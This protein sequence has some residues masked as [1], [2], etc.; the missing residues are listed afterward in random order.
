MKRFLPLL[1]A[2]GVALFAV[3]CGGS[4][5]QAVPADAV[6]VVGDQPIDKA[7]FD[8]LMEQA[9]TSYEAQERDFPEA[10]TPEYN[11][12]RNQA[13]Q[14]LVQRAQFEQK[15]AEMDVEVTDEEVEERLKQIKEQYFGGDEKKYEEQL[16]QQGLSDEQVRRDIRA[17]LIQEKLFEKVTAD[18]E[19]TDEEI[20]EHYEQNKEQYGQP[21]S[22]EVRHILVENQQQANRIRQQLVNGGNFEALAKQHSKDP[23]SA[24]QGGKMTVSRGQTVPEFDKAAFSL[25]KDAISQPVKTQY[26]FHIIQP[27]SAVQPAKTTPLN[28]VRESIRQQLLQTKRNERMT[29]WVEETKQEFA[30]KTRYQ[31]GYAPPATTAADE[32]QTET[33]DR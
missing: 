4:E 11:T 23:G 2:L 10:G 14:F 15:A 12:L 16:E 21:E 13:M 31:V 22:R 8:Q 9:R 24:A 1:L 20:S 7:Q 29:A 30:D 33:N 18:V 3:G 5:E 28:E 26:G 19:V 25:D 32:T 6:A 17:Q 27:L